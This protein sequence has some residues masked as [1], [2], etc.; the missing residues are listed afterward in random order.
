M[1]DCITVGVQGAIIIPAHLCAASGL[2]PNDKVLVQSTGDGILVRP[3]T[4]DAVEIYS[5]ERIA[6]F[7]SDEQALGSHL[8]PNE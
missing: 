2:K 3:V 5:D 8:P 4:D 7:V 6:E 1:D